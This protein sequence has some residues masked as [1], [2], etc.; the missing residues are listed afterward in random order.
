MCQLY[1]IL[2][3]KLN[4][5]LFNLIA[6]TKDRNFIPRI[7]LSIIDT[8]HP[9]NC[10]FYSFLIFLNCLFLTKEF[11]VLWLPMHSG[12]PF[13]DSVIHLFSIHRPLVCTLLLFV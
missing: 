3:L 10:I 9:L 5:A 2:L 4:Y 11:I 12:A 13:G 1:L 8:S 7:E 6:S